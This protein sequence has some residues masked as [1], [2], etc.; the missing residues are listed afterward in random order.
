MVDVK[1][2]WFFCNFFQKGYKYYLI[3]YGYFR[4]FYILIKALQ[5][6]KILLYT[7]KYLIFVLVETDFCD[8]HIHNPAVLT[9][10]VFIRRILFDHASIEGNYQIIRR[11][12]NTVPFFLFDGIDNEIAQS[13]LSVLFPLQTTKCFKCACVNL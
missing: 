7:S 4:V 5:Y 3:Q 11:K 2:H 8:L 12:K 9:V 10:Q 13:K 6:L 1:F